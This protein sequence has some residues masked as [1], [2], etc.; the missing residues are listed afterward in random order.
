M[1]H[2]KPLFEVLLRIAV[3]GTAA[4]FTAPYLV[5]LASSFRSTASIAQSPLGF[6]NGE[7][8]LANYRSVVR[9]N[10]VL[11]FYFNSI[12][13]TTAIVA[14]QVVTS[15][16][17][18]CAIGHLNPPGGRIVRV[19]IVVTLTVPP[20]ATLVA[21]FLTL[22][23]LDLINTRAGLIVP[24]AASAFGVFLLTTYV[25]SVPKA[26]IDAA[27][28][29]ELS[30]VERLRF[31]ILPH[32]FPAVVAFAAFVF[33]GYWNEFFWPLIVL[34]DGESSLAT[35]PFSI[36]RYLLVDPSGAPGWGPMMAAGTLALLPLSALLVLVQRSFTKT[37]AAT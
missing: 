10:D 21:N 26:Q 32:I 13:V 35:I 7:W 27:R 34:Q 3:L 1:S 5:M 24:F 22:N 9:D 2:R 16:L 4:L 17:A 12:V 29:F 23:S 18:A 8:S 20:S 19:I 28:L 30:V 14:L 6:L 36:R 31:V 37:L 33:V 15:V 11:M 25:E